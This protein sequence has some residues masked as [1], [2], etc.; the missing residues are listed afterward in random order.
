[1]IETKR[2]DRHK[3]NRYKEI[4][5]SER[6]MVGRTGIKRQYREINKDTKAVRGEKTKTDRLKST[7]TERWG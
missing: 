7:D 3:A 2:T 6:S 4:Q 5:S 1:M